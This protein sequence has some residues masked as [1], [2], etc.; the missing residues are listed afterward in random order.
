MK[1]CLKQFDCFN[2]VS[3]IPCTFVKKKKV[4][5]NRCG[6]VQWKEWNKIINI[7]LDILM[8]GASLDL[9]HKYQ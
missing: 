6:I 7:F 3:E 4:K 9:F 2:I 5:I 1:P 8:H